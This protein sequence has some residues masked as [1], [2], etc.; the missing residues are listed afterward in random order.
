MFDPRQPTKLAFRSIGR[1]PDSDSG[2]HGSNPWR[3]ANGKR[4]ERPARARAGVVETPALDQARLLEAAS[5]SREEMVQWRNGNAA[6]CKTA[7]SRLDTGLHLHC[8]DSSMDQSVGLL[9]RGMRV[10]LLLE[11]P[12]WRGHV[13]SSPVRLLARIALFQSAGGG[14]EPPRGT[15]ICRCARTVSG[16][17]LKLRP[18]FA[19][20]GSTPCHRCG[21]GLSSQATLIRSPQQG[22]HLPS[23]PSCCALRA[24]QDSRDMQSRM[25]SEALAEEG[26]LQTLV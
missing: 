23:L 6:I 22:R 5:P 20:A 7:M 12:R 15:I 4:E 8:L 18:G 26:S 2:N 21:D 16:Q 25:P 14:S 9:N 11:A 19:R 17:P 13:N 1:T 24:S 3:P 10:Q